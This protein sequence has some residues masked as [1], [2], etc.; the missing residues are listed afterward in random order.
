MAQTT[1]K[2]LGAALDALEHSR[3]T[4]QKSPFLLSVPEAL[5]APAKE[6]LERMLA[7]CR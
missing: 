2:S 6:A 4:G 5:K 3:E 1:E 7:I